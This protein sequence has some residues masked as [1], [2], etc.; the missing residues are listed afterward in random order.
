MNYPEEL[1]LSE[2]QK[3]VSENTR[4][5]IIALD[6]GSGA[7]KSTIATRLKA[8]TAITVVPL[9]DFYQTSIPERDWPKKTVKQ[10]FE[11]AFDWAR[12]RRD[13]LEPLRADQIGRWQA[14]DFMK[15]L[16]SD[17]TYTLQE[18]FTEVLPSPLVLL[19]GNFSA[20][21]FL[22]DLVDFAVLVDVPV[23]ERHR[24]TEARDSAEFVNSWHSIW[25]EVEAYYYNK[26]NPQDSYDLV[27][28]NNT[29]DSKR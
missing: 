24:R 13:A 17:G 29:E 21:P 26:V 1:L 4:P 27:I 18:R 3:R 28:Q 15:G 7:G 22:R 23:A 14:F 12:V 9:D 2:A 16:G 10:R 6:G 19:E 11:G 25:D 5:L 20:S 8:L